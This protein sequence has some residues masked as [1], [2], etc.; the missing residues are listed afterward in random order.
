[1]VCVKLDVCVCDAEDDSEN[2][3]V[4]VGTCVLDCEGLWVR[5]RVLLGDWLGVCVG[6]CVGDAVWVFE[7]VCEAVCEGVRD[8]VGVNEGVL[9]WLAVCEGVRD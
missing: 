8:I 6:D 7:A 3:W 5:V 4:G 2:V 1:M 9:V